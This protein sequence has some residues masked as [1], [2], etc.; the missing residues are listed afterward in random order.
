MS[1][2]SEKILAPKEICQMAKSFLNETKDKLNLDVDIKGC[3]YR[4]EWFT[5]CDQN[6][7]CR[8][9]RVCWWQCSKGLKIM[10]PK[11]IC[12]KYEEILVKAKGLI[13]LNVDLDG[14][15]YH[16]EWFTVCDPNG[17]CKR[18]LICWWVCD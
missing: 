13:N 10:L 5:V 3:S 12:E 14:C 1:S 16:C 9:E 7:N 17:N 18:E 15:S 4:C 2:S 8:R 6:G 11:D